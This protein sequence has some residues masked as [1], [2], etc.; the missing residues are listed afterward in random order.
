MWTEFSD[1]IKLS[2]S[3]N[4]ESI[5]VHQTSCE[6][7]NL[8]PYFRWISTAYHSAFLR[9]HNNVDKKEKTKQYFSLRQQKNIIEQSSP[10]ENQCIRWIS[11]TNVSGVG[12]CVCVQL[13]QFRVWCG[14]LNGPV[15]VW[16][17]SQW[18]ASV[19]SKT[20]WSH[21]SSWD[22]LMSPLEKGAV[23]QWKKMTM[24]TCSCVNRYKIALPWVSSF[25][26]WLQLSGVWWH[27]GNNK[28][29]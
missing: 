20:V 18:L 7:K 21:W 27:V 3:I 11:V 1:T 17:S 22:T 8:Q 12:V 2:E 28:I 13:M 15:W 9:L 19:P 16:T 6:M 24:L 4:P 10:R 23:A 26:F 14:A 25:A 5:N 29:M